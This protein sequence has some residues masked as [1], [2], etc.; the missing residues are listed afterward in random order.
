MN[1]QKPLSD[2][3]RRHHRG[4]PTLSP[5][6]ALSKDLFIRHAKRAL[7][8]ALCSKHMRGRKQ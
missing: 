3:S 4:V 2:P 6:R 1:T 8:R 7:S 5:L